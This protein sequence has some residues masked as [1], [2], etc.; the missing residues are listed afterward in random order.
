MFTEIKGLQRNQG[1]ERDGIM[2]KRKNYNCC[3]LYKIL[4]SEGRKMSQWMKYKEKGRQ[5]Y[6]YL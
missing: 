4:V 6:N 1:M 3:S 5:H 2:W